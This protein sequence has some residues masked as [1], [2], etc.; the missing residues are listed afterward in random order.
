MREAATENFDADW[1]LVLADD[2]RWY[3]HGVPPFD[4]FSLS[5][6]DA[7]HHRVGVEVAS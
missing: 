2:N 3:G 4:L 1:G 6:K 5:N 7:S